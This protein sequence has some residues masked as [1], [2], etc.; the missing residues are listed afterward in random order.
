MSEVA[1]KPIEAIKFQSTLQPEVHR[2]VL[3]VIDRY[4]LD[5]GAKHE[6]VPTAILHD[7]AVW[8]AVREMLGPN[9]RFTGCA[10]IHNNHGYTETYPPH[11]DDQDGKPWKKGEFALLFYLPQKTTPDMGPTAAIVDGKQLLGDGEAGAC[12][13]VR[14]TTL[15]Q[16]TGNRSGKKRVAIKLTFQA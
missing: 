16:A 6:Q 2:A 12:L 4:G 14:H 11:L 10:H 1:V 15:H 3:R 5:E 13:L 7:P 9:A 8:D